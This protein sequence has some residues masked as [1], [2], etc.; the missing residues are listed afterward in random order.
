MI[1]MADDLKDIGGSNEPETPVIIPQQKPAAPQGAAASVPSMIVPPKPGQTAGE[2]PDVGLVRPIPPPPAI[3]APA[4]APKPEAPASDP[5][6]QADI[7]KILGTVK[8]PERRG[9]QAEPK[10][11][12]QIPVA[13]IT[14]QL[15]APPQV[16]PEPEKSVVTAM[17]TLKDDIQ[18]VV[19]VDK[20]SLVRAASL[21]EDRKMKEAQEEESTPARTQRRSRTTAIAF[22]SALLIFLG[23]AAI[24]GV[25]LVMSAQQGTTQK[26][27][28]GSIMFAEQNLLLPIDNT[29]PASLKQQIAQLRAGQVGTLGSITRIVPTLSSTTADGTSVTRP[30]TTQ[31]FLQALGANIPDVLAR[32][33]GSDFFFGMHS[34]DKN[35]PVFVIP[36]VSYDNAFAGMLAW[37]ST[38]NPD[39]APVFTAV[40]AYKTDQNGIPQARAFADT[41]IR[42]YDTRTLSDD[43]N[44]IELYYSFPSPQFLVIAES[45]YTFTEVLARL[46]AQREL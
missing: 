19:R 14:Q 25:F 27:N 3:P 40:P 12:K 24:G 9:P 35:A 46:R 16:T 1:A 43:K 17:H 15:D 38:M 11:Q 42:N 34:A 31:E 6:M 41:V 44:Q 5:H 13:P 29:S 36:V 22:A 18:T 20:I 39:L 30:A 45:P 4:P 7:Q 10:L 33:L 32:S 8:L 21:E 28:T 23:L 26:A 37:E 2:V